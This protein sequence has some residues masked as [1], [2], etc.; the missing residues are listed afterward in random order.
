MIVISEKK[1]A[2][3]PY[4]SPLRPLPRAMAI[5]M[6]RKTSQATKKINHQKNANAATVAATM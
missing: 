3:R 6:D 4:R 5:V 2:N 1:Q